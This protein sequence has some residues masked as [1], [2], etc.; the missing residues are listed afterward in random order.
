MTNKKDR[1]CENCTR[2]NVNCRK[3][4]RSIP[5]YATEC[6]QWSETLQKPPKCK[7]CYGRG[8]VQIGNVKGLQK[9]PSCNGTGIMDCSFINF[10]EFTNTEGIDFI[11][12][13]E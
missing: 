5:K 9:C 10:K 11:E 3:P 6:T 13:E 1:R 8:L 12:V 7:L 2:Y 4:T